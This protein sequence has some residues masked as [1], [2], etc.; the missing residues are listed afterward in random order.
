MSRRTFL[1]TAP[2]RNGSIFRT[3]SSA[4]SAST[5]RPAAEKARARGSYMRSRSSSVLVMPSAT[6]KAPVRRTTSAAILEA[7]PGDERAACMYSRSA[8]PRKPLRARVLAM[9]RWAAE[10]LGKRVTALARKRRGFFLPSW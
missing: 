9:L 7:S 5:S 1:P 8:W 10:E 6:S 2:S 4:F 3:A